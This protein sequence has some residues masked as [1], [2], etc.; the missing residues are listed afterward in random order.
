MP[1]LKTLIIRTPDQVC[2]LVNSY[3]TIDTHPL[4]NIYVPDNLV[5]QYK[6]ATNWIAVADRIKPLSEFVSE[7]GG[8]N[9]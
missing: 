1:N 5:D 4:V 9:D 8:I 2:E 6:V 7:E 3:L